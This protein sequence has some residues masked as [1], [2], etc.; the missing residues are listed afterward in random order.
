M[1]N[2][3]ASCVCTI[4]LNQRCIL[5][6]FKSLKQLGRCGHAHRWCQVSECRTN[7][8]VS[9]S[10]HTTTPAFRSQTMAIFLLHVGDTDASWERIV[11]H[12]RYL[13][14]GFKKIKQTYKQ[15]QKQQ[16]N[17]ERREGRGRWT[18]VCAWL[19]GPCLCV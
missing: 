16:R 10:A 4:Y 19:P 5:S 14:R 13:Q 2:I 15:Q 6:G 7:R 1:Y 3:M 18:W 9:P 12:G 17:A 8:A 11:P